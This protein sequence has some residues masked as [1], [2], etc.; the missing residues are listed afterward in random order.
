MA[1]VVKASM[2]WN[3]GK[4]TVSNTPDNYPMIGK[5]RTESFKS[6]AIQ[7]PVVV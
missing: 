6:S 1:D 7:G 4:E 3:N 2:E 5:C